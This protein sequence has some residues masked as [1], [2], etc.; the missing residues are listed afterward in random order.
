VREGLSGS[1]VGLDIGATGLRAASV[2]WD[3]SS[4]T[5]RV[6][7]FAAL[8][9][10]PGVVV[11]GV[12]REA[13][14]F[15]SALR[16]LWRQGRFTSRRVVFG[17]ADSGLLTRQVDLPWMPPQDF[18]SALRYQV[19][20]VLP[21][22]PAT[23]TLGY[24]VLAELPADPAAGRDT[25]MNRILLVAGDRQ[26]V[27]DMSTLLRKAGLEPRNA[28]ATSFGLIRAICKGRLTASDSVHAIVDLGADHLTMAIYRSGQPLFL[29]TVSNVGGAKATSTITESLS[30]E[31]DSAEQLKR[32]TGLNGPPPLVAPLA[33]SSVFAS[34]PAPVA[35]TQDGPT[36]AVISI[37][38]PW[39][40]TVV[41][42]IRNSLDYFRSSHPGSTVERLALVG[43]SMD[44]TG[45]PERIA[46]EIAVPVEQPDPFAGLPVSSRVE[47]QRPQDSVLL[48]AIGLA[49]GRPR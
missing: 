28:D 9:L 17:L 3:D 16:R 1:F 41:A 24:H 13:K 2:S 21:V 4:G 23:T 8:D 34:L 15:V 42:E 40:S 32:A 12:P 47:R 35:P 36:K 26:D 27:V 39:A 29:R 30:L 44:L 11:N 33:E 6:G 48:A 46:T 14:T 5:Y 49:M 19:A 31:T 7:R 22:D 37:V 18:S 20:D 38:N 45:L 10:P 43:R 25:D